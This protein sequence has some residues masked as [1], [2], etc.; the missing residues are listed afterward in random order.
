MPSF[1]NAAHRNWADCASRLQLGVA[2]G[3]RSGEA[4]LLDSSVF[5][6][7]VHSNKCS[8]TVGG[9]EME[10]RNSVG[11]P[12]SPSEAGR[13]GGLISPGARVTFF[14]KTRLIPSVRSSN[15]PRIKL[16]FL[17]VPQQHLKRCQELF[18]GALRICFVTALIKRRKFQSE[19]PC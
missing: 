3:S 15:S 4:V 11:T 16:Q 8:S 17:R 14:F 18:E 10:R 19:T 1:Q 6:L 2:L 9:C 12:W 5:V 7:L 13:S